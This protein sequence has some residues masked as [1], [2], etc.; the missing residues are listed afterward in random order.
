M[1]SVCPHCGWPDEQPFAVLSQHRTGTGLTVWSRCV[2][3]STQV[4]EI[5]LAGTRIVSRGRPTKDPRAPG[6]NA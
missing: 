2:C 6:C 1:N 5:G 3:G 4:R